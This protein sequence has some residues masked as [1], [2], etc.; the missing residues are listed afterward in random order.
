MSSEFCVRLLVCHV[1]CTSD[2]LKANYRN[3][4][5]LNGLRFCVQKIIFTVII[6]TSYTLLSFV[7]TAL[8]HCLY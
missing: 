2:A 7:Y 6:D 5:L 8:M 4:A 1:S 3:A